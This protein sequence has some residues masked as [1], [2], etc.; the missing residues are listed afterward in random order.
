MNFRTV[1]YGAGIAALAALAY[2]VG[3]KQ[4]I[5][6]NAGDDAPIIVSGGSMHI[7]ATPGSK[8]NSK[9]HYFSLG[10]DSGNANGLA[11]WTNGAQTGASN[12]PRAIA[13]VEVSYANGGKRTPYTWGPAPGHEGDAVTLTFGYCAQGSSFCG[14]YPQADDV[15]TAYSDQK[16]LVFKSVQRDGTTQNDM[17]RDESVFDDYWNHQPSSSTLNWVTVNGTSYN[18]T[19]GSIECVVVIHFCTGGKC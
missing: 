18:C 3:T 17:T 10:A 13:Q 14:G 5:L 12:Y 4:K 19:P 11:H 9:K 7:W 16:S 6:T 15:V 1:A 8:G 2:F